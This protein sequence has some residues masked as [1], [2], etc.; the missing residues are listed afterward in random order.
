MQHISRFVFVYIQYQV[1]F[2]FVVEVANS[3]I[4]A[5]TVVA[6]STVTVHAV[7]II[8]ASVVFGSATCY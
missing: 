2:F 1:S 6:V 4:L 5:A 7:F 8:M 3:V